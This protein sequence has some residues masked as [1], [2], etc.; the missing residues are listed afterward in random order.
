M[1]SNC[2][3]QTVRKRDYVIILSVVA[4]DL[5]RELQFYPLTCIFVSP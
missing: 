5:R 4:I 3:K 1:S 2:K